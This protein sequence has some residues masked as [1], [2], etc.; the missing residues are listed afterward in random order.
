MEIQCTLA[1]AEAEK[2]ARR[3]A[4]GR[5]NSPEDV[6]RAALDAL[7]TLD[8]ETEELRRLIAEGDADVAAGLT[9]PV[10]SRDALLALVRSPGER[11]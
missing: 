1:S 3:M 10:M 9:H 4:S 6:V 5:Y 8:A 7:D 2:I 11:P